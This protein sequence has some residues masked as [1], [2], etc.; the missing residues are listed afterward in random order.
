MKSA[1][2]YEISHC[3]EFFDKAQEKEFFNYDIGR[4]VKYIKPITL[5]LGILF[6][7]FIIPDSCLI[8]NKN[9]L[10][11]IF[12]IRA[13][14]LLMVLVLLLLIHRIKDFNFYAVWITILE[15]V[16]ALAFVT[17]Y[18]FYES[19]DF[20]IQAMGVIIII[21]GIYLAPNRWIFMQIAAITVS[22]IFIIM[23]FYF[24][25]E[26]DLS[27]LSAGI[28]YILIVMILSSISS[29]RTSYYKRVQY[30]DS[31]EL[32]RMSHTDSLTGI[33]NRGKFNDELTKWIDY[34]TRYGTPLSMAIFDFDDF[35]LVND[36]YGHLA[37]DK[38]IVDTVGIISSA[39]RQTDVFARWGGE[40][41]VLLLPNTDMQQAMELTERLRKLVADN[42]FEVEQHITC[43]FGLVS[44]RTDD[45]ED[46]FLRRADRLLYVAK[47]AGK[48]TIAC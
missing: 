36:R 43:S 41:F 4:S 19:P 44:R 13:T 28:V 34:S 35:K 18:Y 16:A 20:L 8:K 6:L 14:F 26:I 42:T 47:E 37:G 38:V 7:L 17:I 39:I 1:N 21:I 11:I 29:Y 9:T 12:A 24:I 45:T 5:V 40:E 25:K 2:N 22:L 32:L 27:D 23:S 31:R 48:N 46:R 15:I 33:Y 30:I 3:G 10:L